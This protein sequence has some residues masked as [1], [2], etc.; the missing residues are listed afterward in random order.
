MSISDSGSGGG[1]SGG[2]GSSYLTNLISSHM[3]QSLPGSACNGAYSW[4]F[5]SSACGGANQ[6]GK[7]VLVLS[8]AHS[9]S[10]LPSANPTTLPTASPSTHMPTWPTSEP[11]LMPTLMT[12]FSTTLSVSDVNVFMYTGNDVH[13]VV[14]LGITQ[15]YVYMW[16]AGGGSYGGSAGG[17]GAY[18]EGW[19]PVTPGQSLT[20]MVGQSGARTGDS[21]GQVAATY[22][23][24]G[25]GCSAG[26]GGGRSADEVTGTE[27]TRRTG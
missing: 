27:G 20:I 4:Y 19:L 2:G 21:D 13:V 3:S 16:G 22:G 25:A 1:S 11:T 26:A 17:A 5:D 18:V 24:G 7:I 10:F 12:T 23:G 14:P 9:S 6:N 8:D 15:L